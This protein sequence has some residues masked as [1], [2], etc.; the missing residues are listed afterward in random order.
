MERGIFF[1]NGNSL[2][3]ARIYAN[4]ELAQNSSLKTVTF[5]APDYIVEALDAFASYS[6]S[7]RSA[8]ISDVLTQYLGQAFVEFAEGYLD[9]FTSDQPMGYRV[10]CETHSLIEN[11]SPNARLFLKK[12][13]AKVLEV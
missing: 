11:L 2:A 13:V 12:S 8:L 4:D 3:Q 7:T 1:D 6:D 5:K 10:Q 9:N